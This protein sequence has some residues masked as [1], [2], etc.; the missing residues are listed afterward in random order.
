[1]RKNEFSFV[2]LALIGLLLI[3]CLPATQAEEPP[4]VTP[5]P[6][7]ALSGSVQ[8][9]EL[10]ELLDVNEQIRDVSISEFQVNGDVALAIAEEDGRTTLIAINLRSEEI[11]GLDNSPL[12]TSS[13]WSTVERYFV[14]VTSNVPS[15]TGVERVHVYDVSTGEVFVVGESESQRWPDVSGDKVVWSEIHE[16]QSWDIYTYNIASGQMVAAVT[17]SGGQIMPKI[18][19]DWIVYIQRRSNDIR[20]EMRDLYLH[21]LVTGEDTFIGPSPFASSLEGDTYGIAN[22]R[23]LWIGWTS[24]ETPDLL[25]G[26]RPSLHLYDLR[27]RT[28][29]IVDL[30]PVCARAP[31]C[32]EMAG[33]L[34]LFNCEG[35][36]YGY[37][38]AQEVFFDVPYPRHSVGSVYF[39]ETY[40]VFRIQVQEESL[41]DY[42]TP[43]ASPMPSE[44]DW[45]TPQ[46]RQ[47]RLFVVPITR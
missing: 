39:S 29:S 14:W 1:M 40:A 31:A 41:W 45:L 3:S 18:E 9:G 13:G 12:S 25:S 11:A 43:G 26:D 2:F 47:Y 5:R 46:P 17:E 36:F 35:G 10:E 33:D 44:E 37:D 24:E 21:N 6:T 8:A 15:D 28:K 19:G 42:V 27:T 7:Q 23:V 38:L 22:G 4:T 34:I 30:S 32:F 20:D 16:D